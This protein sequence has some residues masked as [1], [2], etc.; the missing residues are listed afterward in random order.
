MNVFGIFHMLIYLFMIL[1]VFSSN[2][3]IIWTH[4]IFSISLLMHWIMNN[5]KCMLTE[6]EC[7]T[8]NIPEDKTV[9]RQIL[10]P[11]LDQ[12]SELIVVLTLFGL[13][14]SLFKLWILLGQTH[15]VQWYRQK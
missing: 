12:A 14:L 15:I 2:L 4:M 6:L 8:L 11:I 9:T 1:G 7:Y 5:N 3:G 13:T 10:S